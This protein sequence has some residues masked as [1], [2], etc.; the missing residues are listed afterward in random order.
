[1]RRGWMQHKRR[2]VVDLS[3][4]QESA[5]MER[6]DSGQLDAGKAL[7]MCRPRTDLDPKIAGA[8]KH[9]AD[10]DLAASAAI[11]ELVGLSVHAMKAQEQRQG[12][13]PHI[14]GVGIPIL[15]RHFLAQ[16]FAATDRVRCSFSAFPN[17]VVPHPGAERPGAAADQCCGLVRNEA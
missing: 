3:E 1:M 6:C 15:D 9:R 16:P 2:L 7:P 17:L 10:A 5:I 13:K 12:S 11:A 8:P 4:Q 14:C